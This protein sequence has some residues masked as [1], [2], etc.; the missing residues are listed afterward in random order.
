MTVRDIPPSLRRRQV[1]I[2]SAGILARIV[3]QVRRCLFGAAHRLPA[4]PHGLGLAAGR[5]WS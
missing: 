4:D 1:G 2:V 3:A 5:G